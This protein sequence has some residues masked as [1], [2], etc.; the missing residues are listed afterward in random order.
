MVRAR[1]SLKLGSLVIWWS[2]S[3]RVASMKTINKDSNYEITRLPN[4]Q[5]DVSPSGGPDLAPFLLIL[6]F[7]STP[8]STLGWVRAYE[9]HSRGHGTGR[10]HGIWRVQHQQHGFSAGQDSVE[11]CLH[12]R[13]G[14]GRRTAVRPVL[15]ELPRRRPG[16]W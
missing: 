12:R 16:G 2:G 6:G 4:H 11:R 13:A 14:E 3:C 9:V 10:H 7:N 15:R 5:I 1:E 8:F